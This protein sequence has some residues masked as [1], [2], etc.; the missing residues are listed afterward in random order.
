MTEAEL[1][2]LYRAHVA[3]L[4]QVY[5]AALAKSGFDGLVIHSG[6]PRQQ[7]RFDDQHWPLRPTPAFLHWLPLAEPDCA[8]VFAPAAQ[9]SLTLLRTT[10]LDFWEGRAPAE[11]DHYQDSFDLREV[12]RAQDLARALPALDGFA[13]VGDDIAPAATWGFADQAINPEGLVAELDTART[14]K[15][16][17]ERHCIAE[18]NRRAARGHARVF[19]AFRTGDCSELELHLL[20]LQTTEQDDAETPYKNIVALDA[21]AAVLHHVHYG[22][23]APAGPAHSLLVDAGATCLGYAGDITRTA[24]K[25][26]GEGADAFGALVDRLEAMQQELCTR[27]RAGLLY[28]ELHDQAHELLAE[29]LRELDIARASADELVATGV[30]R[31]FL[32]HGLGHS[33]GLQT[34]DVGARPTVP[35]DENPFL[36]ATFRIAPGH[37]FTIEPGCYFIDSFLDE[38]RAAPEGNAINW[39]LVDL[40]RNFGGVR[41][42]DN[43]AVTDQGSENL[44]RDNWPTSN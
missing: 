21:H 23:R 2:T 31:R 37:V 13:Y 4:Q 9:P 40:L 30:T 8:L 28:E 43:I 24:V 20:Y 15:S 33:L 22:R 41:I 39:P 38:L 19:E 5:A 36:R 17:Y 14:L 42:E 7:N 16:A 25:G 1:S 18:A 32:P 3:E 6:T 11:S 34:H 27:A 26:T 44:T 29:V 10:A 12:E 35:R